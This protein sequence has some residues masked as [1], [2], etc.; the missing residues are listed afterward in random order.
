MKHFFFFLLLMLSV[1][2]VSAQ[3][4]HFSQYFNSPLSLN[5]ALTGLFPGRYRVG[6][7][8]R[9]QWAQSL[10]APFSTTAFAAD[11]RYLVNPGKRRFRDAFGVGVLFA[12]DRVSE[13]NYS[14]NQIMVGG[15]FHKA[16]D[17][18]NNQYL[19]L[20]VQLGVVQRNVSYDQ[21][22]FED[23]F[24]G[25]GIFIE[26]ATGEELP[27][28]N[29]A[30]GDYQI[31]LNYSYAPRN[32]T[33]IFLGAAMHHVNE[34]EQSFFAEATQGEDIEVTN[35]LY[36]RY[37]AYLNLRIP[38]TRDVQLSPRVYAFSQGPHRVANAGSNLRF[39]IND[40]N[41]AA[42]HLGA[43][44]RM[45]TGEENFALD[46]AVGMVGI[47]INSFLLGF[48]YDIGLNGLQTS[49]R[50]QGAFEI[51]LSYTGQADDDEAVPCPQF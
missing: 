49:R 22:T 47:E 12:S 4:F 27:V 1:G 25:T 48:S 15:A 45:I 30:F 36:R 8:N 3:D 16:L 19:S 51:N 42:F 44:A 46:S 33:A 7:N 21:L 10:E 35:L 31:G 20:G 38:L 28:N 34:P 24:D 17:P 40:V 5:P 43:H 2:E 29:Y 41:G 32:R 23:E 37:S 14:V 18:K 9:S 6:I 11:F 13:I 50:H 39:L 26:G